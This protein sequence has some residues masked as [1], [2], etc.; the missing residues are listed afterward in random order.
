[1]SKLAIWITSDLHFG[2]DK[3]FIWQARGFGSIQEHDE[4]I[5]RNWNS[6]VKE[7]DTVYVLGDIIM[8]VDRQSSLQRLSRLNGT[9]IFLRGNHDSDAK[10]DEYAQCPNVDTADLYAY[11]LKFGKFYL[12]L[13]HYPTLVGN[14]D[15]DKLPRT[16]CLHGHTHS[17]DRFQFL[18]DCCYNVS[19]DA[20][21]CYPV[22]VDDIIQDI[23]NEF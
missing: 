1:M 4:G 17:T 8:G 19:L 13:S 22:L 15:D 18:D 3:D 21:N 10:V 16:F 11:M 6:V 9:L 23:R 7:D 5:E 14:F 20:H 2:H 12:Y